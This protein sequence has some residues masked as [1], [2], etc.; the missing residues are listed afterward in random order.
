MKTSDIRSQF[1]DLLAQEKFTTVSREASMTSLV[2]NTTIEIVNASFIADEDSIFGT[3]NWDYVRREEEW[4]NSLS[5]N[6]H[7]IP[8][9]A[10]LVWQAVADADG[11]INS[12]YG[13]CIYSH[14][15]V[16]DTKLLELISNH[17]TKPS[18]YKLALN[19]LKKNP[20]S[21][22]AIMIYTR[23]CM[24]IDYDFNGRSDF[25]CTNAVQ[26]L[27]RDGA[28]HAVVQMRSNDAVFGFKN[29][30][31]WQQ[32][33]LEKLTAELNTSV[34]APYAVGNL[35]WNVGSLHVY[36]RHYHLIDPIKYPNPKDTK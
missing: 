1:V 22:R 6:V 20:E 7:D 13:W 3:V 31:A 19:E 2:G 12:N 8:G 15:N 32:H 21:R 9:G 27:I 34:A 28:V 18:Q 5:L 11:F 17:T 33:V 25:M 14:E 10:P 35:Y 26:Y 16:Y 30:R 24:W 4:Y 29:D 23:P 36:S